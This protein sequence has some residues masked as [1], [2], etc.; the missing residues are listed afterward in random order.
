MLDVRGL[1]PTYW[2]L[3]TGALIN[4]LG[5]F[6][7]PLLALYLTGERGISV[8]QVG[9]V[10]SLY[11]A[12]ALLSGPIGGFFA[13]H[14]GRRRTLIGGLLLGALAMLHLGFA[15]SALHISLAAFLLGLLGELYRPVI[16]AA[17]ADVVPARDRARAYGILYWAVN[18]GFAVG[19]ALGGAMSKY[20]WYLLFVGDAATTLAYAVIVWLRVPETRP[21]RMVHEARQPLWA[22]LRDRPFVA[23]CALIMLVG[24]LFNQAFVTLPIDLRDHGLSPASYGG[25]IALN[26]VLIFLLQ[27]LVSRLLSAYARHRVLAAAAALV[28]TGF[29]MT[30]LVRTLPGYVVSIAV[31]TL[32]EIVM[33]G[34]GPTVA[35]DAAPAAQR[36]A[37]QGLFHMSF[38]VAALAAPALG[39]FVL[40]R[41][42]PAALWTACLGTGVA[43]AAGHLALGTLRRRGE[44]ALP[45]PTLP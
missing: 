41:F 21:V 32:G 34:I 1:P 36:G 11:G 16:S 43:A 30:A 14:S 5:G 23:F 18:L 27:P 35:A 40:G 31:W 42:G 44:E 29:G 17:I 10:V 24:L 9:L 8:E 33:A 39:S 4:R 28:G 15:R 45:S 19:S 20:G 6:V 22:P 38:G 25:L 3:W 7:M 26:G 12:G 37:Y 13:D 2:I